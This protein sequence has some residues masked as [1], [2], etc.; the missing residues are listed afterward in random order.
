MPMMTF[1]TTNPTMNASS[2]A[3]TMTGM[4]AVDLAEDGIDRA[5]DRDHIGHPAADQD[6]GEHR[7]VG[8]R[9]AAPFHAV[10]LGAPVGDEV[11][12]HLPARSLHA[13]VALALGDAD[14]AHR[15]DAGAGGH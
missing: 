3:Q 2:A 9:G 4:L 1:S 6:V 14:L 13:C 11:A 15:L 8:E 12:A 10:G 5:H 7:E